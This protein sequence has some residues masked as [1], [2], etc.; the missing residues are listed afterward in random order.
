MIPEIKLK[1]ID[2]VISANG[3]NNMRQL[4]IFIQLYFL[5]N[6]YYAIFLSP[7]GNGL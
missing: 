3:I 1:K 2:N 5:K 4:T 7:S 6:G